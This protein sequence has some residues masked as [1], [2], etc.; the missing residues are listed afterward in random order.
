MWIITSLGQGRVSGK[1]CLHLLSS[2]KRVFLGFS[3]LHISDVSP[4]ARKSS[5]HWGI[6]LARLSVDGRQNSIA[7]EASMF[8]RASHLFKGFVDAQVG[9]I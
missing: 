7:P 4:L 5:A 6:S 8:T 9:R 3:H 2:P 1:T